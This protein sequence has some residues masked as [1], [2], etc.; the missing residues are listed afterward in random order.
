MTHDLLGAIVRL[1]DVL[2]TENAALK[3]MDLPGAAALVPE[4]QAATTAFTTAHAGTQAASSA[5]L[6]DAAARLTAQA[7]ENRRSAR[8]C[9]PGADAGDRHHRR[10]GAHHAPGAA[11][12]QVRRVCGA[13]ADRVGAVRPRMT[14]R[15][16]HGRLARWPSSASCPAA[17]CRSRVKVAVRI[18]GT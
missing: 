7:E 6:R 16:R 15:A 5:A 4:K 3:V 9:H 11:L 13:G 18:S 12:W 1:A 17:R 14:G 8:A 2:E 10:C